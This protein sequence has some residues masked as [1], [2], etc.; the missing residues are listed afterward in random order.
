MHLIWATKDYVLSGRPMEGF[1]ILLYDTMES[2]EPVNDFFRS[3][4]LTATITSKHSW[5]GAGQS[6]YD[7][8]AFLQAHNL[9]WRDV[10]R[11]ESKTLLYAYRDYSYE[12][13]GHARNTII[14]RMHY[15]TEFYE[16]AHKR[17]L[18]EHLP[19]EYETRTSSIDDGLLLHVDANGN[20]MAAKDATPRK[21]KTLPKFLTK[22]AV[23]ALMKAPM[24]IH[25]RTLIKFAL[26]TGLRR[27]ELA[28]FPVA[29]IK[30]ALRSPGN[31]PNTSIRLDPSDGHGM[32]TKRSTVRDLRVSRELLLQ[33]DKYITHHRGERAHPAEMDN[34]RLFINQNGDA[35]ANDGK[36]LEKIVRDIGKKLGLH[37]HPHMLRH[38]Y[39]TLTLASLQQARGKIDPLVFLSQQLGHSSIKTT[40]I[41][42][43]L[44]DEYVDNAV[45]QY[46]DELNAIGLPDG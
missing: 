14:N 34:G 17:K 22:D 44:I 19:F 25:H 27:L 11:G 21:Y 36:S 2:C 35:Y 8:F 26:Q 41:Y 15:I 37:V 40:E 18:I 3:R 10:D 30:Q 13:H 31:G 28:T 24:N 33:I 20:Q 45:L 23:K 32:K 7:Y 29:Y 42:L 1:P 5:T 4:L 12:A 16:F 43:H 38:T 46:D 39:A 6:M 9:D